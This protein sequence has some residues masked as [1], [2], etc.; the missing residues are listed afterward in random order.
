[1]VVAGRYDEEAG[2]GLRHFT[3]EGQCSARGCRAGA[4]NTNWRNIS[5]VSML[6]GSS[7]I[8]PIREVAGAAEVY[9]ASQHDD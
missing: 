1:M 3:A 7:I 6:L 5:R 8:L 4:E 2:R 9:F